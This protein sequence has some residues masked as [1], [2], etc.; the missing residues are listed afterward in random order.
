[1]V[2]FLSDT[3][4]PVDQALAS[5]SGEIVLAKNGDGDVYWPDL[6]LNQIGDMQPG[7]GYKLYLQSPGTLTYPGN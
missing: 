6:S 4:M 5:I 2:A 7:Q 1:M 3:S